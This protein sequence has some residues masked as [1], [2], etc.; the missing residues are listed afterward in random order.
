M[1]LLWGTLYDFICPGGVNPPSIKVW[2]AGQTLGRATRR[3]S[4]ASAYTPCVGYPSGRIIPLSPFLN[5]QALA[6]S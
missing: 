2:P 6:S 3:G 5:P 4:S 1:S